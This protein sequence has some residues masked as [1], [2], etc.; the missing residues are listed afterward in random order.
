MKVICKDCLR[1][2]K[3]SPTQYDKTRTNYHE[4]CVDIEFY[5]ECQ[6]GMILHYRYILNVITGEVVLK[7]DCGLERV[8]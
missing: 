7:I 6:C 3:P 5:D 4:N 2:F 8:E 1:E